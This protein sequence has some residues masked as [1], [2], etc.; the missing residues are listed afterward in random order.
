VPHSF[1]RFRGKDWENLNPHQALVV[2]SP[3]M[4]LHFDLD[5]IAMCDNN[6]AISDDMQEESER[7]HSSPRIIGFSRRLAEVWPLKRPRKGH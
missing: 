4:D 3:A 5:P 6:I 7:P 2:A 1:P